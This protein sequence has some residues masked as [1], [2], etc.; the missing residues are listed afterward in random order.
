MSG[1]LIQI[2]FYSL[3]TSGWSLACGPIMVYSYRIRDF[4]VK[5]NFYGL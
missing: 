3:D 4:P 1:S 5:R 2:H